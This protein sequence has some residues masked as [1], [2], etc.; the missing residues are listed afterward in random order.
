MLIIDTRADNEAA[1]NF[2]R[3]KGFVNPI[4]HIYMTLNLENQ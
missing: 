3:N 2:F 4:D 1:I